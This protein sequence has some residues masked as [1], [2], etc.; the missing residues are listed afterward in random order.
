M[1]S[2]VGVVKNSAAK[3]RVLVLER[4]GKWEI[5]VGA[6]LCVYGITNLVCDILFRWARYSLTDMIV[7]CLVIALATIIGLWGIVSGTHHLYSIRHFRRYIS[8]LQ[9]DET[10]S[11]RRLADSTHE[12][13]DETLDRIHRYAD[14]GLFGNIII[15]DASGRISFPDRIRKYSDSG[16]RT[17]TCMGCGATRSLPDSTVIKC[18]FCG[19]IIDTESENE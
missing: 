1:E 2:R 11:V 15:D 5:V 8:F 7:E 14:R 19:N 17:V 4:I 6:C 13:Y 9:H 16:Y 3:A 12:P 18:E 10:G